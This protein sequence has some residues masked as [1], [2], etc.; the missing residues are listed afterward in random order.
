MV[1]VSSFLNV[2]ILFSVCIFTLGKYYF[3]ICHYLA[4]HHILTRKS[5]VCGPNDDWA[6]SAGTSAADSEW[7]V[8]AKDSGWETIG[9]FEGCVSGAGLLINSPSNNQVFEAT[10]T[11]VSVSIT[12]LNFFFLILIIKTYVSSNH[13]VYL[14]YVFSILF[15]YKDYYI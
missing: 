10:T 2:F 9:S 5:T 11:D 14:S 12:I 4:Y 13:Y 8:G 1:T 7:I 15:K 3:A 6:S